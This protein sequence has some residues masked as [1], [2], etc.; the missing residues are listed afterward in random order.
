MFLQDVTPL[1]RKAFNMPMEAA[2]RTNTLLSQSEVNPRYLVP[3]A[4][5]VGSTVGTTLGCSSGACNFGRLFFDY[6][7]QEDEDKNNG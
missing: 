6:Y 7:F 1:R 5:P 4:F 2:T 3:Q